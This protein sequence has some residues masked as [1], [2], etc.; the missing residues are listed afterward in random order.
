MT[1]VSGTKYW[2]IA[3]ILHLL[4]VENYWREGFI[5]LFLLSLEIEIFILFIIDEI[6]I[7]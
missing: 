1:A 7:Y 5:N 6:K 2:S 4:G 3:H